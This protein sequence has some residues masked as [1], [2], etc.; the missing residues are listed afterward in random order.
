MDVETYLS[1]FNGISGQPTADLGYSLGY[2][3]TAKCFKV[4]TAAVFVC[5]EESNTWVDG[6]VCVIL[7]KTHFFIRCCCF[8]FKI[9][10][11]LLPI[12][13]VWPPGQSC[14]ACT[15]AQSGSDS[16]VYMLCSRVQIKHHFMCDLCWWKQNHFWHFKLYKLSKLRGRYVFFFDTCVNRV[17]F[18]S[19]LK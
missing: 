11:L 17:W 16:G 9:Y 18:M 7:T 2:K 4:I 12:Y 19:L 10:L 6:V 13:A 8:F 1:T 3:K 5:L 15:E 14:G